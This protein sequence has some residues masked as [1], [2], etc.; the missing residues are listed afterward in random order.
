MSQQKLMSSFDLFSSVLGF[1]QSRGRARRKDSKYVI[2]CEEGKYEHQKMIERVNWEE[3]LLKQF[4][5]DRAGAKSGQADDE[6]DDEDFATA[7]NDILKSETCYVEPVTGARLTPEGSIALIHEYC[8]SLPVDAYTVAIPEFTI[9]PAG[10]NYACNLRLPAAAC[11]QS[12]EYD[13]GCTSRNRAKRM[14]AFTACMELR[15]RGALN[16]HHLPDISW[17]LDQQFKDYE[18]GNKHKDEDGYIAGIRKTRRRYKVKKPFFFHWQVEDSKESLDS[19]IGGNDDD[20]KFPVDVSPLL[21]ERADLVHSKQ[22]VTKCNSVKSSTEEWHVS[23]ILIDMT[24]TD[25]DPMQFRTLL[26]LTKESLPHVPIFNLYFQTTAAP[27]NFR[28]AGTLSLDRKQIDDLSKY[29]LRL[30]GTITNKRFRCKEEFPYLLAP[31]SRRQQSLNGQPI[32]MNDLPWQEIAE[33]AHLDILP[34]NIAAVERDNDFMIVDKGDSNRRYF[35]KYVRHDLNP[36]S[37]P[38]SSREK[39]YRN[40]AEY[41]SAQFKS[42]TC[43]DMTQPLLEVTAIIRCLNYLTPH[44]VVLPARRGRIAD[45]VIPEFCVAHSLPASVFRTAMLLPSITTQLDSILICHDL[46]FR[47]STNIDIKPLMEALTTPSAGMDT[48]YQRLEF[49]GDAV[50]KLLTTVYLFVIHRERHEGELNAKRAR[51]INNRDLY[52]HARSL[53]IPTFA[54]SHPFQ[55]TAWRPPHYTIE[56]ET[57]QEGTKFREVQSQEL[58]DKTAADLVEAILGAAY[59]TGGI[60]NALTAAKA[61][62]IPLD[63]IN[64]WSDLPKLPKIHELDPKLIQQINVS[65]IEAMLGYTFKDKMGLAEGLTHTSALSQEA[66][67]YQRVEF[68]GDA[69]LDWFVVK[70]LYFKLGTTATPG[71]LTEAKGAM[72]SNVFLSALCDRLGLQK[73]LLHCSP[74]LPV[75]MAA[76]SKELQDVITVAEIELPPHL[77]VDA[78][79]AKTYPPTGEYWIDCNVEAPKVMADMVEAILG[80]V[81]VDSGYDIAAAE[82]VFNRL[83]LPMIQSSGMRPGHVRI[84]PVTKLMLTVQQKGCDETKIVNQKDF[85]GMSIHSY[86]QAQLLANRE[87]I[88]GFPEQ[89]MEEE[90]NEEDQEVGEDGE[91]GEE[92]LD[93]EDDYDGHEEDSD[94]DDSEEEEPIQDHPDADIYG[95]TFAGDPRAAKH[96]RDNRY[97]TVVVHGKPI[98]VGA[99]E[100][101]RI[102]RKDASEKAIK[103]IEDE[104]WFQGICDCRAKRE[105]MR[106]QVIADE[107]EM[108]DEPW[109]LDPLGSASD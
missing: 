13:Q 108:Q 75:S 19:T 74:K 36:L 105:L 56:K 32:H 48:H 103:V 106:N 71:Q 43:S 62:K 47:L 104:E 46:N 31:L 79:D 21:Q 55:R 20:S 72:V 27:V 22:I 37:N 29:T 11:I 30:I 5:I 51:I 44:G 10:N 7:M 16:E 83:V 93:D 66:G 18:E 28:P 107:E 14:A 6:D 12:I 63:G 39:D 23:E 98:A 68:L 77:A 82:E 70:Y 41:Y 73:H 40:I 85:P 38:G 57:E 96:S 59:I 60:V 24:A 87:G 86:E 26:F 1:I 65:A 54:K 3:H 61:L 97:V 15:K 81:F 45:F 50:L 49:L 99:G 35:A 91:E 84:H 100:S 102:S 33:G 4:C 80:A 52:K 42:L 90:K 92:A 17:K 25:N 34:L 76:Y 78:A 9:V 89:R 64:R 69:L 94:G 95:K 88:T 101:G 109:I 67:C 53:G 58:S 8:Q 2:M